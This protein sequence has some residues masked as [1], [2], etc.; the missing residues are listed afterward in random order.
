MITGAQI[1]NGTVTTADIKDGTLKTGDVS[2]AA[3]AALKGQQGPV[4]APGAEGPA[5]PA[6]ATG[7]NGPAGPV[8]N[9][10]PAGASGPAG[11]AGPA[12]AAGV[13]GYEVVTVQLA[14]AP[15]TPTSL[16]VQCPAGK[17]VLGSSS[18]WG[19]SNAAVQSFI[20]NGG[21]GAT[22]FTTGIPSADTLFTRV[23]CATVAP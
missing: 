11:P 19:T 18:Y 20:Q 6:G 12:G 14:V 5:G 17:R 2:A 8:G 9:A 22:S 1:K 15:N 3:R 13:L 23:T 4:G 21:G 16:P 10:G 7:A